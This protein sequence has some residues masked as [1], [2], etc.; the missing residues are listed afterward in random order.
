MKRVNVTICSDAETI[1]PEASN[2]ELFCYANNLAKL[3]E[4]EFNCTIHLH[5][6]SNPGSEADD[7]LVSERIRAVEST[8]EWRK[9][10][11]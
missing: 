2:A 5:F 7:P 4:K 6:G 9:L 3:L 11:T 8:D 10:L 1:A